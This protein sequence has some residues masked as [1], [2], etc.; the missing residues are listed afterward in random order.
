MANFRAKGSTNKTVGKPMAQAN[1]QEDNHADTVLSVNP[2]LLITLINEIMP[3]MM[4]DKNKGI[5][6][7]SAFCGSF[8]KPNKVDF[9][10]IVFPVEMNLLA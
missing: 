6:K 7:N 5:K 4:Q 2:M 10:D 3:L 8:G 9:F 1:P